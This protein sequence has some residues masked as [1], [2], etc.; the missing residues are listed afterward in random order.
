[1]M[2]KAEMV[3]ACEWCKTLIVLHSYHGLGGALYTDHYCARSLTMEET[4]DNGIEE[5]QDKDII[6]PAQT[7]DTPGNDENNDGLKGGQAT[8]DVVGDVLGL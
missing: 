7:T 2:V 1:M 3:V 5:T 8:A 4:Q 6:E